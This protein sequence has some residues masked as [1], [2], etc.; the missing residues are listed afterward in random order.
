MPSTAPAS[1][2]APILLPRMSVVIHARPGLRVTLLSVAATIL[3]IGA[4]AAG[5]CGY[6]ALIGR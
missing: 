4:T 6:V 3:P 5:A 2:S 1:R